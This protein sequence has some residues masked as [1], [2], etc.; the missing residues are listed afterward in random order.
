MS[1]AV[2]NIRAHLLGMQDVEYRAFHSKLMPSVDAGKIIGVRVP[3]LRAYAKELKNCQEA[4]EFLMDLPHRYYEEDNLHAFLIE[5]IRDFDACVAALKTFLP[6]VDN[7]ATCDMMSPKVLKQDLSR[8]LELA[9]TWMGS[10]HTYTIRYGIGTLMRFFLDGEFSP[11][12][13]EWVA[14][15]ESE[16]YYVR[17]MAAWYFATA[18]AKQYDAALPFIENRRLD[19]WTHNKAIQKAVESW[20]IAPEQKEHLKKYKISGRI[21]S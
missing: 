6:Y 1:G 14:A 3:M 8:T 11:D 7:W 20:R 17:M 12:H 15:L 5:Q 10:G 9:R 16:E 19:A 2:E 18:L 21:G 4:A 13:L